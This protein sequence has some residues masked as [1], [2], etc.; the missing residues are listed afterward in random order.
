MRLIAPLSLLVSRPR[1]GVW[2]RLPFCI[3]NVLG[4]GELYFVQA[5]QSLAAAKVRVQSLAE[6]LPGE[7]VI[8]NE[9]TGERVL[10]TTQGAASRP[11]QIDA[12]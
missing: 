2:I 1:F 12:W 9:A 10:I 3:R 11:G 5:A 6:L 4:D 7:F 8:Y